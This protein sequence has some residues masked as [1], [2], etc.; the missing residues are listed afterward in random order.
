MYLLQQPANGR[1]LEPCQFILGFGR[2]LTQ[3]VACSFGVSPALGKAHVIK[4][5]ALALHGSLTLAEREAL[6]QSFKTDPRCG[7]KSM[8]F[9]W[10]FMRIVNFRVAV[11]LWEDMVTTNTSNLVT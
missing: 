9:S 5:Q 11:D 4:C 6:L 3:A 10:C 2:F 7:S 1:L 8:W